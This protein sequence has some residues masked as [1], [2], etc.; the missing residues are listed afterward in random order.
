M[1]SFTQIKQAA[2]EACAQLVLV[3]L[4]AELG[5]TFHARGF[6]TGGV[7]VSS[8]IDRALEACEQAVIGA[9][10]TGGGDA[11][12]LRDWFTQALGSVEFAD[13][14]SAF[15]RRLEVGKGEIIATQ[16]NPAGS[17]HFILEGRVG[18]IVKMDDGRSVRVRSLGPRTTIGEMGLITRQLRSATIR[19]EVP[20]GELSAEAYERLKRENGPL[21]QALLTYVVR[22]MAERL[23]FSSRV[24]GV[25]RR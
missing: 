24:I 6:I 12:S 14:L 21:A 9:R 8:D 15:S 3:N 25:L 16:G 17:M 5:K 1:H 23:S 19:A 22:V 11:A 18:I 10:S 13:Q 20:S 7:T 2:E 4:P